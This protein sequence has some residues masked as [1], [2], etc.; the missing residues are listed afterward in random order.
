[1]D[2][3]FG[4]GTNIVVGNN[5]TGKSTLLEAINLALKCQLGRRPAAY[6][7]HPFLFNVETVAEFVAAHK[8]R[9]RSPPP[10]IMIELYLKESDALAELQGSINTLSLD[11]PGISLSIRL[12]ENFKAEYR[13][14]ISDPEHLNSIP[15]EFYEIVWLSFAGDPLKARA[16]PLKSVL[17]DPSSI[18]NTNAAN[19]YILEIV[20]D[21]LDKAQA[22]DLALSYR[23]MRDDFVSDGRI[24][25]INEDLAAKTGIVSDKT[26]SVAM[27]MTS[28]AGWESGVLPHLDNIPLTLIGKGEQNAVKVKLAMEASERCDIFLMEEPENHLSH[29]NLNRLINKIIEKSAG[30]QIIITTH[31]S[32]VLNKLGVENT[33]MFNGKNSFRLNDLPK[34]TESYFRKLPGYDTLRMILASKT[35]LVE[36]PSDELIVQK[37]FLQTHGR[38]PLEAGVEVISVNSLAFKRFLDIARLL[39]LEVRVI[40]DNDG[41]SAARA[42]SYAPYAADETIQIHIGQD[43]LLPT[44]EPQLVR[45]NGLEKLNRILGKHF[46]NVDD[47]TEYMKAHKSETALRLFDSDEPIDIPG[48]IRNAI[49]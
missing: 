29:T 5:E 1:M 3:T 9:K 38:L 8:A 21:Y 7:L 31:S 18:S 6:E 30:R 13:E 49:A 32:F 36:G 43:D 37:A 27:D 33:L 16:I 20:R 11:Q 12:D 10:E 34:S 14:Y 24:A 44:L 47:L 40:G 39:K 48:Y 41:K 23:K 25:A 45:V 4:P 28:K 15:V 46:A 42:L 2:V 26:L 19:R 17:I 22:V 35:L